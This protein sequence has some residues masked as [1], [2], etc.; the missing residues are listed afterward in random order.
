MFIVGLYDIG[1][2]CLNMEIEAND[3][4]YDLE[5]K[6]N[7]FETQIERHEENSKVEEGVDKS[8]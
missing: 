5:L 6:Y 2:L 4:F 7:D 3:T 8:V 1:F